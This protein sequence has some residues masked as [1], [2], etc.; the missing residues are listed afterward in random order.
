MT[1]TATPTTSLP[2][3]EAFVE[4]PG[5]FLGRQPILDRNQQLIAYE[6]LYRPDATSQEALVTDDNYASVVVVASL[7]QDLG[8]EQV[9]GGKMGFINVG[10]ET[11]GPDSPL[12][13]LDPK[14]TVLE[15]SSKVGAE[16]TVLARIAELRKQGYGI[17]VTVDSPAVVRQPLFALTT[18]AK[19]DLL[20]V[21]MEQLP[22]VMKLLK[23]AGG[24]RLLV[25]EKV[26]TREQAAACLQLGFD[27]LQGFYFSRP[28]TLSARK[29]EPARAAVMHAIKLLLRN[30]DVVEVD[31]A[32]KRDVALSVKLLRYMN[33]AGMGLSTKIDSLKHAIALLGYQKLARWLTLLLASTE[34][35]DPT[36]PLLAR[37]AIIRGRL[38][39][40]L[41]E[42]RFDV[43]QR[44]NL[45]IAGTF[46]LLPAM[47]MTPMAQALEELDLPKAV[48]DGLLHRTGEFAT[49][50][51]LAE[52]CEDPSLAGVAQLC[53]ELDIS[54]KALNLAQM[55][56]T[57]WVAQLGI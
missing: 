8:I 4:Q 9:L 45:F 55:Q 46:S 44:D 25:A 31:A 43:A 40:L 17:A 54:P 5:A 41:G 36:A 30:A 29:L 47:L 49:L 28:E 23:A 19:V 26:E 12:A 2:S 48:A 13:L 37:T 32:L 6:L 38:M 34:S 3:A 18:H 35:K 33:S 51:K 22:L 24:R 27:C 42:G 21:P 7:L 56:A 14:H 1:V 10:A 39:E 20:Q 53:K 11:L 16:P 15:F 57:D 52:A 50:L